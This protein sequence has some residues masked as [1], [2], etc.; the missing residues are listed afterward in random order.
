MKMDVKG[1]E[2]H[3]K[4]YIDRVRMVWEEME[5]VRVREI[6]LRMEHNN[7]SVEYVHESFI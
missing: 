2:F 6:H 5:W 7:Q 3:A 1:S 4:A